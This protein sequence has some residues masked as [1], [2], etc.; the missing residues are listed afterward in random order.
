MEKKGEEARINEEIAKTIENIM[1]VKEEMKEY[2]K[3]V[4]SKKSQLDYEIIALKGE[5]AR[6]QTAIEKH[7]ADLDKKMGVAPKV[8]EPKEE[9]EVVNKHF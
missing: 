3:K 1:L 9:E 4:S 5:I 7:Q 2:T 8:K 6:T